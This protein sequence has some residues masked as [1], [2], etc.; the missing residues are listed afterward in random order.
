[1]ESYYEGIGNSDLQFNMGVWGFHKQKE[2]LTP[3]LLI[4]A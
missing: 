1:M 2:R 3:H 4:E